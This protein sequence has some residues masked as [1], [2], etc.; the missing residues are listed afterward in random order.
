MCAVSRRADRDTNHNLVVAKARESLQVSKQA[1]Q[2]FDGEKINLRKVM[3]WRLGTTYK[4]NRL[5]LGSYATKFTF[6]K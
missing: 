2:T 6:C 4:L 5:L 3:S 1:E